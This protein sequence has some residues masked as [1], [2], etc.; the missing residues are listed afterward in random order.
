MSGEALD[1]QSTREVLQFSIRSDATAPTEEVAAAVGEALGYSFRPG[2][3]LGERSMKAFCLGM[4]I[5]LYQ[6]QGSTGRRVFRLHGDVNETTFY[7]GP[8]GQPVQVV[9]RDIS[10]AV[11]T[12]L[13]VRGAGKWWIP[14]EADLAAELAYG[15]TLAED[16]DPRPDDEDLT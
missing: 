12:L 10:R 11:I 8:D 14:T 15:A 4:R 3:Y 7:K 9:Q 13:D 6:W 2:Q 1:T 16:A 5:D